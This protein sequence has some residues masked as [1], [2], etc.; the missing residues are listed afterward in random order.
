[1]KT[2]PNLWS[3]LCEK[4][5]VYLLF[6]HC[7]ENIQLRM[8][9]FAFHA[10]SFLLYGYFQI[11]PYKLTSSPGTNYNSFKIR[12]RNDK[13]TQSIFKDFYVSITAP[14]LTLSR[15]RGRRKGEETGGRLLLGPGLWLPRLPPM[16]APRL[17]APRSSIQVLSF[18]FSVKQS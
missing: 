11:G 14:P 10:L 12:Q 1:M 7:T 18:L 16:V 15:L 2:D 3:V 4:V 6:S 13:T 17:E 5:Y 9:T 8:T